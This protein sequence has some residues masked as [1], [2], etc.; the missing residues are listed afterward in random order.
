[1]AFGGC[2]GFPAISG[3]L[4]TN[5]RWVS[6][7]PHRPLPG[8]PLALGASVKTSPAVAKLHF[9]EEPQEGM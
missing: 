5:R 7:A 3:A 1:M 6:V 4:Q 8:F 2:L 9:T